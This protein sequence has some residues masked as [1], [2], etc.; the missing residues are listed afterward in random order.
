MKN[1]FKYV[2]T[3]LAGIMT[4]SA[5]SDEDKSYLAPTPLSQTS[6]TAESRPGAIMFRWDIPEDA[7][8]YYVG[9]TYQ[10]P[11]Q[12]TGYRRLA[13]IYTDSLLIDGLLQ[14]YGQLDFTFQTFSRDG[15]AST[16]F[17]VSAQADAAEKTITLTG[18]KA[19]IALTADHVFT[20]N[21]DYNDPVPNMLDGNVSTAFV[22]DWANPGPM[23]RYIVMDLQR[24]VQAFGFSYTTRDHGNRDD[25]KEINIY[26]SNSF[27]G[28]FDP[29]QATLIGSIT[30]GLPN[31]RAET[32][33]SPTFI[34]SGEPC[35]YIWLEITQTTSG[36]LYY[37]L[38]EIA[39]TEYMTTVIDPEEVEEEPSMN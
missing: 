36:N 23:P 19:E 3:L 33:N 13:S 5:C 10:I 17:I 24:A 21:C 20:D 18:D 28:S 25:P 31:G 6:V 29:S 14:R 27:D 34:I 32:Y 2:C 22:S 4:F 9:V 16:S 35:N 38:S 11:G 30:S 7:N 12:E 26:G 15:Q 37:S 39:A 1:L 8:Y